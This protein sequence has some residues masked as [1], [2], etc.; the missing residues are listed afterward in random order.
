MS[1]DSQTE[2]IER[3]VLIEIIS[4]EK[5]SNNDDVA[6]ATEFNACCVMMKN[7]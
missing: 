4:L 7:E 6:G 1:S 3:N 2:E 5:V